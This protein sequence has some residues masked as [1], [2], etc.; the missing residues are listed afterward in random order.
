MKKN[1]TLGEEQLR[2]KGGGKPVVNGQGCQG[3]GRM[4]LSSTPGAIYPSSLS[5]GGWYHGT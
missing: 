5:K 2:G 4:Q 3:T 1:R